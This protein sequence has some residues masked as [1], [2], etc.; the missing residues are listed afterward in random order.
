ML[1]FG[2]YIPRRR[3][4]RAV[5]ELRAATAHLYP[6]ERLGL[7]GHGGDSL[8]VIATLPDAGADAAKTGIEALVYGVVAAHDGSV[9]AEHGIG[10][11][12]RA[13]LHLSRTPAEL[14]LLR[15][16][17]AALDPAGILNDGRVLEQEG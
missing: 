2:V 12:K 11:A 1:G 10:Q 4:P 5:D 14:A 17:K 8:H 3:L 6:A 15:R 7:F 16:L 13:W 9:S